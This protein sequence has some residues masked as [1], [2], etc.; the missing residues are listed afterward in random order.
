MDKK[1]KVILRQLKE[2]NKGSYLVILPTF[3]PYGFNSA[4]EAQQLGADHKIWKDIYNLH[5]R[6]NRFK[7]YVREVKPQWKTIDTIEYAD[8]SI[9][10]IQENSNGERRTVMIKCPIGDLF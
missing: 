6:Y 4:Y 10:E 1:A 3:Y 9:E 5:E 2:K 7:H 8:N